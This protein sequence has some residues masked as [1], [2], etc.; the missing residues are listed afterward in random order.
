M[1]KVKHGI[2]IM[3]MFMMLLIGTASPAASLPAVGGVLPDLSP[4]F[5]LPKPNDGVV[6][7]EIFSIKMILLKGKYLDMLGVQ[8]IMKS[9]QQ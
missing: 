2:S 5:S 3:L 8:I 1:V 7:I 9:Y 4:N 6:I